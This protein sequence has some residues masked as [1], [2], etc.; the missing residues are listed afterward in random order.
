MPVPEPQLRHRVRDRGSVVNPWPRSALG[1]TVYRLNPGSGVWFVSSRSMPGAFRLVRAGRLWAS[2]PIGFSCSCPKGEAA[3][4]I[5]EQPFPMPHDK[6][7]CHHVRAAA[8]AEKDD[9][10]P[11]RPTAP[12][13]ISGLVD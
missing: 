8:V 13:N 5:T 9:G 7:E 1:C 4:E 3:Q 10:V 6:P 12:P 2:E 11:P